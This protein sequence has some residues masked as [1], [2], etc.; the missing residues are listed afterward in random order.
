MKWYL[1][2]SALS[3]LCFEAFSQHFILDK[4]WKIK[5]N[6]EKF[7]TDNNRKYVFAETDSTISYALD[8]TLS[9]PVTTVFYFNQQDRCIKQENIFNCDS[10]LQQ[11]MQRSLAEKFVSWHEISPGAYYAGFP[12]H[13]L[14]EQVRTGNKFILRFSRQ[15]K[16]DLK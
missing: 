5:K 16:K 4:R 15:R 8:D 10:C 14:M 7:Y 6:M 13:T 11:S 2:L 3:L 9:L 1:L 12:Y